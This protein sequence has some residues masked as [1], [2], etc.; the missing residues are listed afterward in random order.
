MHL[1]AN[2]VYF[3]STLH[4]NFNCVAASLPV[5]IIYTSLGSNKPSGLFGHPQQFSTP[6]ISVGVKTHRVFPIL[7]HVETVALFGIEL[8]SF[9]L[10]RLSTSRI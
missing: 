2:H 5:I 7:G 3:N 8:D 9:S 6:R 10:H 1:I 4:L